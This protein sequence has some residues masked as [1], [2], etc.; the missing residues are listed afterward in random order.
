MSRLKEKFLKEVIPA[1][2]K[3]FGYKNDL[4]APHIKKVVINA[5]VGKSLDNKKLL[6]QIVQDIAAIGGQKPVLKLAKKSISS[7]KIREGIPVGVAVTL[8]GEKMYE[9]VDK[10]INIALPRVRDF[11]GLPSS[12]FDGRGNYSLG[13][14]EHYVFPE[15]NADVA[16]S[17]FGLEVTIVT[18]A[19]SDS[20]AKSLLIHL[21][22]PIKKE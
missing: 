6:D 21:G 9:F 12:S 13:I 19:K 15:I 22:F 18:N 17:I 10:L 8:R 1:M 20:E 2:R 3:E 5:G 4:A 14:R 7:F 11:R 16:S